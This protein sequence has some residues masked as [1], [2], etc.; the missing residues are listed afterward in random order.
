MPKPRTGAPL[1][2]VVSIKK[3]AYAMASVDGSSAEITLY[4]DI[5][6]SQPT[7]WWGNPIEGQFILLD[8][9]LEDLK[10]I[11]KQLSI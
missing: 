3:T 5:Y 2:G 6:E 1:R 11:E 7:D 9:F 8:E 4:G 10:A